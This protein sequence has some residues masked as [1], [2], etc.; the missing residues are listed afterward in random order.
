[1]SPPDNKMLSV[2]E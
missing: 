1:M 2:E